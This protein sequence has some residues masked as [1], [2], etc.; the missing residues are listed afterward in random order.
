MR[1]RARRVLGLFTP[2]P[3]Y[4]THPITPSS[5]YTVTT[6]APPQSLIIQTPLPLKHPQTQYIPHFQLII[7]HVRTH[8]FAF[9]FDTCNSILICTSSLLKLCTRFCTGQK[10]TLNDVPYRRDVPQD[11][12]L[13]RSTILSNHTTHI[14]V[15][16]T[17]HNCDRLQNLRLVP[18][19]G[20]VLISGFVEVRGC[21]CFVCV[22]SFWSFFVVVFVFVVVVLRYS[23]N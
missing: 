19:G 9:T 22:F 12:L 3:H 17:S 10:N 11:C 23:R 21:F 4:T 14:L 6:V 13:Q 5:L 7:R 8:T 1:A 16:L 18:E 20:G 2:P 15:L